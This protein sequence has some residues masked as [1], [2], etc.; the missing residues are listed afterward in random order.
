MHF[1]S[2]R[3]FI[4]RPQ[5]SENEIILSMKRTGV[6]SIEIAMGGA[7][8]SGLPVKTGGALV[9]PPRHSSP[10][11][12]LTT[13][14]PSSHVPEGIFCVLLLI[15]FLRHPIRRS[16]AQSGFCLTGGPNYSEPNLADNSRPAPLIKYSHINAIE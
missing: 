11:R 1:P 8:A 9:T 10:P 16:S 4:E 6:R 15:E 5:P 2:P 14:A 12:R 13:S 3:I 7:A